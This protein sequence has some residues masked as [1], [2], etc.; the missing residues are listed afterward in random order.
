[1]STQQM[2]QGAHCP[3]PI[4]R[5][6]NRNFQESGA[7]RIDRKTTSICSKLAQACHTTGGR[8]IL[9]VHFFKI[10]IIKRAC[11]TNKKT[12]SQNHINMQQI[13]PSMPYNRGPFYSKCLFFRIEIIKRAWVTNKKHDRKTT[14]ICSKLAQACYTTWDLSILSVYFFE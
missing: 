4:L 2:S 1:M 3:R 8:S 12:W 11:V 14:S 6:M 13:G 7:N 9:S 10:E 5:T